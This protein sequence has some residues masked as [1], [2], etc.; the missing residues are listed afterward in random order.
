MDSKLLA[1]RLARPVEPAADLIGFSY[2][3]QSQTATWTGNGAANAS[4][5]CKRV[6]GSHSGGGTC[7]AY[8]NYCTT[9]NGSGPWFCES[10]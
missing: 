6:N 8:G 1:F 10:A 7:N 2:D 5:Y 9:Y 4:K 3:P